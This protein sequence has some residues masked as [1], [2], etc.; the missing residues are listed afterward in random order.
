MLLAALLDLVAANAVELLFFFPSALQDII[1]TV[2]ALPARLLRPSACATEV[3][4]ESLSQ[5]ATL[6]RVFRRVRALRKRIE[7]ASQAVAGLQT[8][9]VR[10]DDA[11]TVVSRQELLVGASTA[12][13]A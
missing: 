9:A 2:A 8:R 4:T 11:M 1:T 5:E 6:E 10:L 3:V 7:K 13:E 12:A